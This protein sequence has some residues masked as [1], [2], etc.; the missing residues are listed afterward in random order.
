MS[1][2]EFCISVFLSSKTNQNSV[3]LTKTRTRS[4]KNLL[5]VLASFGLRLADL[6]LRPG[7]AKTDQKFL[8]VLASFKNLDPEFYKTL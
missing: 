7:S 3:K 8:K 2:G 6:Q 4:L 1:F 5:K